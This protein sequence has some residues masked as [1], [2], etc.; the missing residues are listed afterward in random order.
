MSDDSRP[1][2]LSSVYA[3]LHILLPL[4]ERVRIE[5]GIG[6][7]EQGSDALIYGLSIGLFEKSFMQRERI[8]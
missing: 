8:R 4:I 5:L 7:L 2:L 3:G 6:Q 1:R